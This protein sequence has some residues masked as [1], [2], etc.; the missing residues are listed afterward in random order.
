MFSFSFLTLNIWYRTLTDFNNS[1]SHQVNTLI[2]VE[3]SLIIKK[4]SIFSLCSR[5]NL[6]DEA[7]KTQNT[8]GI[9]KVH[10]VQVEGNLE[11]TIMLALG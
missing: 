6:I 8:K 1:N 3:R 7:M 5:T 2:K 11:A 4:L 9:A 10:L